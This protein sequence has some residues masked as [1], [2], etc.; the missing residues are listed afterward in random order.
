MNDHCQLCHIDL[1]ILIF[2]ITL[3]HIVCLFSLRTRCS[4]ALLIFCILIISWKSKR[5]SIIPGH[6]RPIIY[7][8]SAVINGY[9]STVNFLEMIE[10]EKGLMAGESLVQF[11][12]SCCLY[13]CTTI[14]KSKNCEIF[15]SLNVFNVSSMRFCHII[16]V[17]TC[18]LQT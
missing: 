8:L 14:M 17:L 13:S 12:Y 1:P 11:Q 10:C 4:N 9:I 18:G 6:P 2:Q 16:I 7:Q 5:L 15:K 3:C